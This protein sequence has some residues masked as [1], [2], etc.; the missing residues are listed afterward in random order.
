MY[1]HLRKDW[2]KFRFDKDAVMNVLRNVRARQRKMINMQFDGFFEKLTTG[3][4]TKITKCSSDTA[5]ND[6][7][8]SIEGFSAGMRKAAVALVDYNQ[9]S[10][11]I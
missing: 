5:L 11:S 2:W 9:T 6:I 4:W 10:R 7:R 1:L 3:K 8:W